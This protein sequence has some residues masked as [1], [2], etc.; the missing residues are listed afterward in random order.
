MSMGVGLADR[1]TKMATKLRLLVV[2]LVL[3]LSALTIQAQTEQFQASNYFS[4]R[5]PKVVTISARNGHVLSV[6]NIPVGTMLSV[7]LVKGEFHGPQGQPGVPTEF[8]GDVQIRT[9]PVG[10]GP[11]MTQMSTVPFKLDVHDVLVTIT[12][13]R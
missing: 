3:A 11:V 2:V 13:K 9:R 10:S 6:I 7:H 12:T 5:E 8:K 4:G 1:R